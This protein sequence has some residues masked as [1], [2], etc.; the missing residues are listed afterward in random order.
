MCNFQSCGCDSSIKGFSRYAVGAGVCTRTRRVYS[1]MKSC[2]LE[3]RGSS[4]DG[5]TEKE[6]GASYPGGEKISKTPNA[7][8]LPVG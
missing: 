1:G 5:S 4:E 7:D 6:G 8:V 2:F 3:I